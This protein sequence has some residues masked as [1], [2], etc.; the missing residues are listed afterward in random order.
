MKGKQRVGAVD[1]N[2]NIWFKWMEWC[3]VLLIDTKIRLVISQPMTQKGKGEPCFKG[4][5]R[6]VSI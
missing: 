3:C 2:S 1:E 6:M 5:N 4:E